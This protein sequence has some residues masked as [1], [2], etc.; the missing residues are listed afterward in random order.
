LMADA[1]V[2]SDCEGYE[3][4]LFADAGIPA[5][6]TATIVIEIHEQFSPGVEAAIESAFARTHSIQRIPVRLDNILPAELEHFSSHEKALATNEFRTA[7]QSWLYLIPKS[8]AR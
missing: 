6:R 8:A 5:L 7:Q 3:A 1:F 4:V 2:L